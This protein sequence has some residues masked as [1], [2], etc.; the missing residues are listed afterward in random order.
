MR[1]VVGKDFADHDLVVFHDVW[2]SQQLRIGFAHEQRAVF[3][4]KRIEDVVLHIVFETFTRYFGDHVAEN[5]ISGVAVSEFL[6]GRE[7]EF[8]V[9]NAAHKTFERA[10]VVLRFVP[11]VVHRIG[12]A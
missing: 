11:V 12:N 1:A 8:L 5:L 7:D 4:G 9:G 2:R 10:G 3:H 6:A